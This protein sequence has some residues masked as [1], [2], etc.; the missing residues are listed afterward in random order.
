[1]AL[2]KVMCINTYK[3][4]LRVTIFKF[5][6]QTQHSIF[7]LNYYDSVDLIKMASPSEE[8]RATSGGFAHMEQHPPSMGSSEAPTWHRG[9][10]GHP[11]GTE[12]PSKCRAGVPPMRARSFSPLCFPWTDKHF[13][14]RYFSQLQKGVIQ[15]LF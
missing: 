9:A 12:E 1:M 15:K 2:L 11:P 5:F 14:T 7:L 6:Q 3:I 4:I 13:F 8:A 10:Q